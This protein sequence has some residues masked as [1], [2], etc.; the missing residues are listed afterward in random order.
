[1]LRRCNSIGS[2]VI[3][4]YLFFI[5]LFQVSFFCSNTTTPEWIEYTKQGIQNTAKELNSAKPLRSYIDI[6][7]KQIVEDLSNQVVRTNEAFTKRISET[8][9]AKTVLEGIH[10]QTALKVNNMSRNITNLEKEL[11][12]KEGY[13]CLCQMRLANRAQRNGVELCQDSVQ[14]S[15]IDELK[16]LRFTVGNLNQILT[17]VN[18]NVISRICF[19]KLFFFFIYSQNPHKDI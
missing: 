4:N 6:I 14:K 5:I 18:Y 13:L 17:Q 7:L 11:A 19:G 12:D 15:L 8:R 16:T 3:I 10:N 2:I 9:Y 1:M